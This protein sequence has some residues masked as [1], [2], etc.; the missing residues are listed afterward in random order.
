MRVKR[1]VG[2]NV[3]EIMGRVKYELGSEAVILQTRQFR[4]GGLFGLFGKVKV[5]VTAAT[6]YERREPKNRSRYEQPVFADA[7]K[8]S[9]ATASSTLTMAERETAAVKQPEL[10]NTASVPREFGQNLQKIQA[11]LDRIGRQVDCLDPGNVSWPEPLGEWARVLADHGFQ[12]ALVKKLLS[13]VQQGLNN[14]ELTDSKLVRASLESVI[15]QMCGRTG[16]IELG[17]KKPKI[18][19]FIGPTGV[20]KTTTIGKLAAGFSIVDKRKIALVTI[21]TYRVAAVEQLKTFGQIIGAPVEV[22]TTPSGLNE[23]INRHMDKEIIFIDTAGRSPLHQ[24]HMAELKAFIDS[25]KP[26]FTMLVVSATTHF[27]VQQR[28]IEQFKP[29]AT[30]LIYTKLDETIEGGTFL[31]LLIASTLPVAYITD[32]QNVPD[33]IQVAT[34]ESLANFVLKE[35]RMDG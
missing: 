17:E 15:R 24:L 26:D 25:A 10:A 1:F 9:P 32:G 16:T 21:D 31:H 4:E 5:E 11:A 19:A 30:H 8:V 6:D 14:T 33:D 20:G 28:V 35:V 23:I 29:L 22:A 12:P 27:S 7:R 13:Q 2:D 18:V 3:A 34:P